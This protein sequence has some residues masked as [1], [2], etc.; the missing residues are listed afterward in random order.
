VATYTLTATEYSGDYLY[1]IGTDQKGGKDVV[2]GGSS[3]TART[4]VKMEGGRIQF[5]D[6]ILRGFSLVF[7]GT[8]MTATASNKIPQF[9]G[10]VDVWE[11]VQ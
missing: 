9:S 7:E 10:I 6:N 2:F 5:I 4:P 3:H 8:K 11:K 1:S